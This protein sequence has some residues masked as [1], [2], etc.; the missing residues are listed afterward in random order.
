[1]VKNE[2]RNI[3][4][5]A[6]FSDLIIF[7]FRV[8]IVFALL[9]CVDIANGEKEPMSC[10]P[11]VNRRDGFTFCQFSQL[12]SADND[13]TQINVEVSTFHG[14]VIQSKYITAIMISDSNLDN[15]PNSIFEE[16]D[17][18]RLRIASSKLTVVN[19][20]T[21]KTASHLKYLDFLET[22]ISEITAKSFKNAAELIEISLENCKVDEIAEDAFVGLQNLKK[23]TITG[24]TFGDNDFLNSLPKSVETI[25]K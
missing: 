17:V 14:Q 3:I 19:K 21:F 7:I 6:R 18:S 1:M 16:W 12:S 24:S 4:F 23:I 20:E 25:V 13:T 8:L 15:I 2:V 9:F 10:L 5:F 22:E 11:M